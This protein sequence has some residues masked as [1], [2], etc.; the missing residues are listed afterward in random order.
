MWSWVSARQKTKL[1]CTA[2][3]RQQFTR[4]T[5]PSVSSVR[6]KNMVKSLV[7]PGTNNECA[8]ESQKQFTRNRSRSVTS[9]QL[10][11]VINRI[12]NV[13]S[14]YLATTNKILPQFFQILNV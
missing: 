11:S 5:D 8:G 9:R 10:Q 7:V 1:D 14:R 13:R 6:Q 4:P 3:G 12:S 2:E